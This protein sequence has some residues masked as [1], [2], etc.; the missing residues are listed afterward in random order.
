M[1][2]VMGD[3]RLIEKAVVAIE[4]FLEKTSA[5]N[6]R[7]AP[8]M[9]EQLSAAIAAAR[10][11][12]IDQVTGSGTDPVSIARDERYRINLERLRARLEQIECRLLKERD[13]VLDDRAL[14]SQT[15]A[16]RDSLSKTR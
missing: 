3:Q 7:L 13:R 11:A 5:E 12:R 15:L 8:A 2:R 6:S 10:A 9:L 14:V 4:V 16:W 1:E